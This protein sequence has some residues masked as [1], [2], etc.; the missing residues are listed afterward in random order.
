MSSGSLSPSSISYESTGFLFKKM[1]PQPKRDNPNFLCHDLEPSAY[2]WA[3]GVRFVGIDP[4]PT[5]NNPNHVVSDS[6]IPMVF[7]SKNSWR[8]TGVP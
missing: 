8:T 4:L 6:M 5:P 2:L 3:R 1:P 7:A